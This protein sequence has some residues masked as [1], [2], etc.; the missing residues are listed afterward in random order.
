MSRALLALLAPTRTPR[1]IPPVPEDYQRSDNQRPATYGF[2]QIQ[3]AVSIHP[4]Q[5][6]GYAENGDEVYPGSCLSGSQSEVGDMLDH[7]G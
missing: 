2:K 5:K 3:L 7:V 1:I 6:E 4:R